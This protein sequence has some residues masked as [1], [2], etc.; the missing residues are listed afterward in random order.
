MR[1]AEHAAEV[2]FVVVQFQLIVQFHFQH[3]VQGLVEQTAL[4]RVVVVLQ[5]GSDQV[6]A[7]S[8][9]CRARLISSFSSRTV[10]WPQAVFS[11]NSMPI[12]VAMSV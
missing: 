12:R 2:G 5:E 4:D 11:S 1:V 10:S 6:L 8:N 9:C 3:D 7:S